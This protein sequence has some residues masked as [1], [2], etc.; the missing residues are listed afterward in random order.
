MDEQFTLASTQVIKLIE[1]L[2]RFDRASLKLEPNRVRTV[3]GKACWRFTPYISNER[4][5]HTDRLPYFTTRVDSSEKLE[6]VAQQTCRAAND[7]LPQR[8]QAWL[9]TNERTDRELEPS[10]CFDGPQIFGYEYKCHLCDGNGWVKCPDCSNGYNDCGNCK[11]GKIDCSRCYSIIWGSTGEEDCKQCGA[12]GNKDGRICPNCNGRK[13][14][15]C[16]KCG[17]A[18]TVTCPKCDG[19]SKIPCPTCKTTTRVDCL[20]CNKTGYFHVLRTIACTVTPYWGVDLK[21]EK[22]EVVRQLVNRDLN[23]LRTL[24][25]VT[26]IPPTV[27]GHIVE[28]EYNIECI[29][30]ELM[31]LVAE[32][33][34]ELVGY[35]VK[36]EIFDYKGIASI[37]LDADLKTLEQM[38][39]QTPLRMWGHPSKLFT[40]TKEFLQSEVNIEIDNPRWIQQN[41]VTRDYVKQVKTYLPVALQKLFTANIGLAFLIA[42]LSPTVLF[43]IGHFT[44]IREMIGNWVFVPSVVAAVIFWILLERRTRNQLK[45]KFNDNSDEKLGEKADGLFAKYHIL[46]KARGLALALTLILLVIAAM[47]PLS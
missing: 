3:T 1:P 27:Q 10:D 32:Q 20:H 5:E 25:N 31:V 8:I 12:K 33:K 30:T 40:A 36:A 14:V 39:D 13:K 26:Q 4:E 37:I 9:R 44:G 43:F 24:A 17:G 15:K 35:G 28:R 21:D 23:G 2:T 42:V 19:T 6:E 38:V 22:P 47:L 45:T 41:F 11:K 29:I 34:I 16:Q 18:K 7:A 46:W